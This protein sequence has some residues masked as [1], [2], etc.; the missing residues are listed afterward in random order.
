M[1][2]QVNMSQSWIQTRS[3]SPNCRGLGLQPGC[4]SHPSHVGH[5]PNGG[6]VS[7]L[8]GQ[9][10]CPRPYLSVRIG[11]HAPETPPH[12][13]DVTVQRRLRLDAASLLGSPRL[14]GRWTCAVVTSRQSGTTYSF[15]TGSS[16]FVPEPW[17]RQC[18]RMA[19]EEG[20][21]SGGG[22]SKEDPTSSP[23][24]ARSAALELFYVLE[25]CSTFL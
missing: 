6:M 18:P 8:G 15:G 14:A 9:V 2:T 11:T 19:S 25:L 3:H 13:Q 5:M 1:Q 23:I 22:Q 21:V 4:L 10:W 16:R 12:T 24:S 20:Q 7:A 17:C